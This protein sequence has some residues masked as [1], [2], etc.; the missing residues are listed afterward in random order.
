MPSVAGAAS[1]RWG[2]NQTSL[3]EGA[4][5]RPGISIALSTEK[6][7]TST[8]AVTN[9]DQQTQRAGERD[10]RQNPQRR[11]PAGAGA[12]FRALWAVS[13]PTRHDFNTVV[14]ELN[15]QVSRRGKCLREGAHAPVTHSGF[16]KLPSDVFLSELRSKDRRSAKAW[17][18]VNTAGV[19]MELGLA[20]LE[21]AKRQDGTLGD[22]A[23]RITLAET[24]M[25][26]ALEVLLM[27]A[28]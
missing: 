9:S 27:R 16:F 4:P 15:S 11:L 13:K 20:V 7:P 23:R 26:A 3:E 6:F 2:L 28:H 19:W 18:Y 12:A 5:G 14:A 22:I 21:V 24:S 17:E 10:G 1:G 25:K 8:R